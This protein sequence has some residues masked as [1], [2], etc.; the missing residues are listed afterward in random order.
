MAT[1]TIDE[2]KTTAASIRD[3]TEIGENTASRVGSS[4]YDLAVYAE[5][6]SSTLS[7]KVQEMYDEFSAARK[8]YY[9]DLSNVYTC[10]GHLSGSL[11]TTSE[12]PIK[13]T[14]N[15]DGTY[16]V[17]LWQDGGTYKGGTLPLATDATSGI[18]SAADHADLTT[19]K[20]D[21]DTLF[22][23]AE[24]T[25]GNVATN[26]ANIAALTERVVAFESTLAAL[27]ERVVALESTLAAITAESIIIE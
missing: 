21:I 17:G 2:I 25:D 9:I 11:S 4:V 16:T 8:V 1:K 26:A 7:P 6:T 15:A 18:M 3:A 27:T 10:V 24:K 20:E 23:A 14:A 22:A 5:N 13:V 12:P 19:A